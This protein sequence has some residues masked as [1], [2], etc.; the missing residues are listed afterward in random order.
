MP[1]STQAVNFDAIAKKHGAIVDF[2]AIAKKHGGNIQ[3]LGQDVRTSIS[4]EK[5]IQERQLTRGPIM[6]Y[7]SGVGESARSMVPS[8]PNPFT[9]EYWRQKY[10]TAQGL[11]EAVPGVGIA[12]GAF[13]VISKYLQQRRQGAGRRYATAT[14]ASGLVPG[15]DEPGI[16]RRGEVGDVAGI[17][18]EIT[19]PT[20][21]AG[22]LGEHAIRGETALGTALQ[23]PMGKVRKLVGTRIASEEATKVRPAGVTRTELAVTPKEALEHAKSEGINLTP[24][25]ASEQK[26]AGALQKQG[27]VAAFGGRSLE[28]SMQAERE[29][30]GASVNRMADRVDPPP[31]MGLSEEQAGESIQQAAQTAKSVAHENASAAY[32]NLEW[33]KTTPVETEPLMKKWTA[34]RGS[35]PMGAEE[36]VL[37]Q[38]P[39]DM[40]A[41][42]EEMFS[43]TG[44]KAPLTFDQ[45]ISL[46][47]LFRE[48]GDVEGLP[49]RVQ[50]VFRQ[51]TGA[52]DSAMESS[53]GKARIDPSR[54][55]DATK[56]WREAN[57][58][59]KRYAEVYG[60]RQSPLYKILNTRDP[61][62]IT[63]QLLS[64]AS[65]RDVEIL[66]EQGMEGALRAL[67]R[68]VLGDMTRKG[69][70][71][72]TDGLGGY[73]DSFLNELFGRQAAK[74]LY[75]KA[76]LARRMKL[77]VNPSGTA[78]TLE[79][80]WQFFDP[81][82]LARLG[83]AAKFS[84][85]RDPLSYLE[86]PS[87]LR[88]PPG[89][90]LV[91]GE[92]KDRQ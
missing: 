9:G 17:L 21:T 90:V 92:M 38:V 52:T 71:V 62:Q 14:A 31:R 20:L 91:P 8:I 55:F 68:Q 81:R 80:I 19:I 16:R 66:R 76:D 79:G 65:A 6:R 75:V 26:L 40:R 7:L 86:Q 59:W 45:A 54:T 60:D 5:F 69:F 85:P 42:V 73:S 63:R 23:K 51:M 57:Q 4:G 10:G 39:R 36:Q 15:L 49:S 11:A 28:E 43:P 78:P 72:S 35:L 33:T 32:Q 13:D 41:M 83:G 50:G 87:R 84:M 77:D 46:R 89:S 2:D 44:I 53:A 61:A 18:G 3:T 25:Q 82:R 30:F 29:K 12:E 70:R 37:A 56:E 34:L 48:L 74:E 24:F 22:L 64:R 67:K 27:E 58:R 1:N 47:S 88:L